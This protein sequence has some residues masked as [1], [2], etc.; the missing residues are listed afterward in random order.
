MSTAA[1]E[2]AFD[3]TD[4]CASEREHPM[5]ASPTT[6]QAAPRR[7]YEPEATD[8]VF[9]V[10]RIPRSATASAV[11]IVATV[12]ACT[13]PDADV[14]LGRGRQVASLDPTTQ[15]KVYAAAVRASFDLSN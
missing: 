3:T 6:I 10:M 2:S 14:I 12:L 9:S 5:K 1:A 4:E 11:L 7:R 8:R 13:D 15:A